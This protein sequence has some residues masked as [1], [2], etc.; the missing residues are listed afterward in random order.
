MRRVLVEPPR[1]FAG[2]VAH[3]HLDTTVIHVEPGEHVP[4]P[5]SAP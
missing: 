2:E 1:T 3:R 5:V 4:L